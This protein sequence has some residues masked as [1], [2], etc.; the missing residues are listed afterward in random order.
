[1]ATKKKVK[2]AY[3]EIMRLDNNHIT[4]NKYDYGY[5]IVKL[6]YDSYYYDRNKSKI[7][8]GKITYIDCLNLYEKI[9]GKLKIKNINDY[10]LDRFIAKSFN[11]DVVHFVI[12]DGYY[13]DE[14]QY[15]INDSFGDSLNE[16]IVKLNSNNGENDS[17]LIEEILILE[18]GY[19]LPEIKN[20]SWRFANI[21]LDYINPAAGMKHVN[22]VIIDDY[23]DKVIDNKYNLTCVCQKNNI[24]DYRLIDGYHRFAA[25]SQ[26]NLS[27]IDAIICNK[28]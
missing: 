18:Y 24:N 19:I 15:S 7:T 13:G 11:K 28:I 22:K 16:F 20:K 12:R 2:L 21:D 27:K 5:N 6:D 8:N 25:T 26:L 9:S 10:C 17:S 3:K 14:A 23:K 4:I 1:M